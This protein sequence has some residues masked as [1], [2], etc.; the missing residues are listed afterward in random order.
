M[1]VDVHALRR[2]LNTTR[3]QARELVQRAHRASDESLRL[4]S[5]LRRRQRAAP[6]PD[7]TPALAPAVPVPDHEERAGDVP[8]TDGELEGLRRE[9][10]QLRQA[11]ASRAVVD[12]ARGVLMAAGSCGPQRAWEVL[13]DTS[14]R[15]NTKLRRVAEMVV[16]SAAGG[17]EVR[18]P[19]ARQLRQSLARHTAAQERGTSAG[20]AKEIAARR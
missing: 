12:Q 17:E 14:Q 11:I 8:P 18:G 15:T 10:A 2:D 6:C 7:R 19:V 9:R 4:C 5:R 13:V 20:R 3:E 1:A 16:A